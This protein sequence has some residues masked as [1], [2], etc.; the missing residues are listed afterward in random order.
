MRRTVANRLSP[1]NFPQL[2]Y[3]ALQADNPAHR[4]GAAR[5]RIHP[6]ERGAGADEVEVKFAAEKDPRGRGEAGRY[7]RKAF[8][9]RYKAGKLSCVRRVLR[10]IRASKVADDGTPGN[11]APLEPR[12][13][14][15]VEFAQA[16]PEAGH[17]RV[18]VQHRRRFPVPGGHCSPFCDLPGIVED[19][20]KTVFDKLGGAAW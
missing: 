17:S 6:I 5:L 20:E 10:F 4:V 9:H 2:Q 13:A 14:E 15:L 19:G 11:V 18:D 1:V 12:V 16:Q 3:S 8:S 7:M